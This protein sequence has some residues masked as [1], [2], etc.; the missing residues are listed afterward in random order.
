MEP[1][2]TTSPGELVRSSGSRLNT[3]CAPLEPRAPV[4]FSGH[5]PL[6]E[7]LCRE[8]VRSQKLYSWGFPDGTVVENLPKKAGAMGLISRMPRATGKLSPQAAR[9]NLCPTTVAKKNQLWLQAVASSA[10]LPLLLLSSSYII[11][12]SKDSAPLPE[13]KLKCLCWVHKELI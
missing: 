4:T 13:R 2:T 3:A 12:V 11:P 5:D 10:Y 8:K 9:W 1:E 7:A 6:R